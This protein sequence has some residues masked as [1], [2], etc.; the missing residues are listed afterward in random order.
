[1]SILIRG[2]EMPKCCEY[3]RFS[4][5]LPNGDYDIYVKCAALNRLIPTDDK[6]KRDDCPLI[7]L[8]THGDLIDRDDLL[9]ANRDA[10]SM[11]DDSIMD[12]IWE[13][14]AILEAEGVE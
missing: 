14:P 9:W 12:R 4:Y 11:D 5:A 7:E 10:D 8:P 1:M 13:A 3:C 6:L 2:M